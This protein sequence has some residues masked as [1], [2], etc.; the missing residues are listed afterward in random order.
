MV[1]CLSKEKYSDF[2]NKNMI[3]VDDLKDNM[4][5]FPFNGT[6]K[7][8]FD[9]ETCV[10]SEENRILCDTGRYKEI[11]GDVVK[12]YSW[13]LSNTSNDYILYGE[14]LPQ[15]FNAMVD[16]FTFW[17]EPEGTITKRKV[18]ECRKISNVDIYVHNL[19]YDFSFIKYFLLRNDFYY[20]QILIKNFK[21]TLPMKLPLTYGV[22]EVAGDIY[23]SNI[24]LY[25][26][27]YDIKQKDGT[28]KRE[29]VTSSIKF[30]DS[31]KIIGDSID[32]IGKKLLTIDDNFLKKG[33]TYDYDRVRPDGYILT[34][35]EK[36]YLYNDVYILKEMFNQFYNSLNT[37][38]KTASS[39]AYSKLMEMNPLSDNKQALKLRY[40]SIYNNSFLSSVVRASYKG[41]YTIAN[42]NYVGK[43]I[44]DINGCSIDINSSYPSAML[45]NPLPY[46]LPMIYDGYIP[47]DDMTMNLI[48][49]GFD[50]FENKYPND[51]LGHFQTTSLHTNKYHKIGTE[52]MNSSFIDD[53]S[54]YYTNPINEELADIPKYPYRIIIPI[55]EFEFNN[56]C[57]YVNFYSY[58]DNSNFIPNHDPHRNELTKKYTILKTLQFNAD[59]GFYTE[60]IEHFAKMK[61]EGANEGNA[62]KKQV[63]K[64]M[65]NSC[66]GKFATRVERIVRPLQMDNEGNAVFKFY[67]GQYLTEN[68]YYPP[69]A[70]AITAYGRVKLKTQMYSLCLANGEYEDVILYGDTD[71]IYTLLDVDS[72]K[73]IMGD[74]LH[75]TTLGKWDIEKSNI[76]RFKALGAKKYMVTDNNKTTCKCAGLPK[77]VRD[78][79][80]YDSFYLGSKFNNKLAKH[81]VKGGCLLLKTTFTIVD[82]GGL[83]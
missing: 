34:Q 74:N 37:N 46:G 68:H 18:E 75:P 45:N 66:Y 17:L 29:Y 24:N 72:V 44:Q 35:D 28:Y 32:N 40:P 49:V 14:T 67:G 9:T 76:T 43:D 39:I 38:K 48:V 4:I 58:K 59:K 15:F 52:Y 70:S 11:E 20:E 82:T 77:D 69:V 6:T 63:A 50:A 73:E 21:R 1:K 78:T 31:A 42:N 19:T 60:F 22:T 36:E 8:C 64:L 57:K 41:G 83:Y 7:Y 51:P 79:I 81:D 10:T 54:Y 30:Y 5:H 61:I 13:A 26:Y 3:H 56:L 62:T 2:V 27:F 65:L 55:W 80:T 33:D 53:I 23:D 16:L 25:C 12:V 47:S 71:S